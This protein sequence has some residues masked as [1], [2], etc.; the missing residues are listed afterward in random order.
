[1]KTIALK[2]EVSIDLP[3]YLMKRLAVLAVLSGRSFDELVEDIL[4]KEIERTKGLME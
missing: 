4:K 1:M 2:S 3:W